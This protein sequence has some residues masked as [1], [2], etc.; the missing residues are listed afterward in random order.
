MKTTLRMN[1]DYIP[2]L[3]WNLANMFHTTNIG[4]V[5]T[6]N[7]VISTYYIDVETLSYAKGDRC[8]DWDGNNLKY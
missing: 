8:E 4:Y 7:T 2:D 6:Q 3:H 1:P 5:D